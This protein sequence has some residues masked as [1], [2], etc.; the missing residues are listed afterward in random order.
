[1]ADR[2]Y[3]LI[4]LVGT[5]RDSYESAINTALAKASESLKDLSWFEVTEMRGGLQEGAVEFQIKLKVAF[6][7]H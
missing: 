5:S 1:M 4:E 3:K 6:K 2:T 7:V